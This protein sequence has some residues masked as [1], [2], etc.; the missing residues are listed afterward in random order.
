MHAARKIIG[1]HDFTRFATANDRSRSSEK[2]WI[3]DVV[4]DGRRPSTSAT[5]RAFFST[6]KVR[7]DGRIA[8]VGRRGPVERDGSRRA[9]ARPNPH[10]CRTCGFAP[11]EGAHLMRVEIR[12]GV[13]GR[14]T[15]LVMNRHGSRSASPMTGSSGGNPVRRAL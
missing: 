2:T 7:I 5:R 4:R 8:D 11:P 3:V 10:R 6:A 12:H 13:L 14:R 1:K 15:L 9:L